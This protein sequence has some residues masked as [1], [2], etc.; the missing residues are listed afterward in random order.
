MTIHFVADRIR[1]HIFL[2]VESSL[3]EKKAAA[4]W[5]NK[6]NKV[7]NPK[8]KAK[9]KPK[10]KKPKPKVPKQKGT[11]VQTLNSATIGG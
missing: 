7:K 4:K 10:V 5:K 1:N 8:A 3:C 2:V 11:V 6:L 9:A